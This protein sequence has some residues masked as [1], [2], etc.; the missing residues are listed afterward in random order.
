MSTTATDAAEDRVFVAGAVDTTTVADQTAAAEA[1][2]K[3]KPAADHPEAQADQIPAEHVSNT[4]LAKIREGLK[5]LIADTAADTTAAD[6][7]SGEYAPKPFDQAALDKAL[8]QDYSPPKVEVP[9]KQGTV[10][11]DII[12]NKQ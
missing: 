5:K 2:L 12:I 6:D 7:T 4:D 3:E 9:E 8:D 1:L 10:P 11:L